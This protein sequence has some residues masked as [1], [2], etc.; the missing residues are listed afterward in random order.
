M[1]RNAVFSD[2]DFPERSLYRYTLERRW[3]DWGPS[4]LWILLNPST[5]DA[6]TDDPTN[7]RGINFSRDWGYGAC[8]FVNLFAYRTPK[9][10]LMKGAINPIGP[11]NDAHIWDQTEK[12]DDIIVAWGVNGAYLNRHSEILHLLRNHEL[13][14][15]GT[16]QRG[17]PKHPLFLRADTDL[18]IYE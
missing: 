7:R 15:L 11:A 1:I 6:Q 9:P 8:V 12:C 2:P 17:Y 13:L 18:R 5:A 3:N 4:L 16:T 14:C 10:K